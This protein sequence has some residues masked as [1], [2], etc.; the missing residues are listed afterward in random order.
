MD[1]K[2]SLYFYITFSLTVLFL[3]SLISY[4]HNNLLALE[5]SFL[6]VFL[7]TIIQ[8]ISFYGILSLYSIFLFTS[9]FFIYD[10]VFLSIFTNRSF[11][12][13][14]YPWEFWFDQ[15]IGFKFIIVCFISVVFGHIVYMLLPKKSSGRNLKNNKKMEQIGILLMI[16]FL[17]PV[18]WKIF[19]QLKFVL[20]NGYYSIYSEGF[21]TLKYPVWCSGAFL[22]FYSGYYLFVSSYPTNK[23]FIT[24]SLLCLIVTLFNAMKGG[25]G[26]IIALIITT[27]YVYRNF[28]DVRISLKK[29]LILFVFIIFTADLIGGVRENYGNNHIEKS[30]KTVYEKI[31][32][33]LWVQTSS[34]TVLLMV[35]KGDLEYHPYPFVFYPFTNKIL[36][37]IYKAKGN[38]IESLLYYNNPSQVTMANVSVRESLAGKGYGSVFIAEAYECFGVFGLLFFLYFLIKIINYFDRSKLRLRNLYLPFLYILL[39]TIPIAPR[40]E[41]FQIIQYNLNNIIFVYFIYFFLRLISFKSE[42]IK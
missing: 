17:I 7:I 23:K 21:D 27:L 15:N 6:I 8:S 33:V 1:K 10:S 26:E 20:N 41:I 25:R 36:K 9:A 32:D 19:L 5:I 37:H 18:C 3:S 14:L 13:I 22:F 39:Q 12:Q 16:I 24:F 2:S 34:R 38:E 42:S 28:Y 40:K 4:S 29:I 35:L 31:V 11:I 30:G